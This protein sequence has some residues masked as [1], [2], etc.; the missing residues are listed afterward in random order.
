[1]R[2]CIERLGQ[3]YNLHM[4][5]LMS[6]YQD[7]IREWTKVCNSITIVVV[8]SL[9]SSHQTTEPH[10]YTTPLTNT[11]SEFR[12]PTPISE[13]LFKSPGWASRRSVQSFVS[14]GMIARADVVQLARLPGF[15]PP[16][17]AAGDALE[18]PRFRRAD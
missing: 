12:Q 15:G 8:W 6:E 17:R 4:L 18:P 13:H 3:A 7:P 5:P 10:A 11:H 16:T 9:A 2:Q 14:F 1:M